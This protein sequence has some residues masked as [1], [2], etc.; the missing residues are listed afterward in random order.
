MSYQ[1]YCSHY[2]SSCSSSSSGRS[3][4]WCYTCNW[5]PLQS[6]R[7]ICAEEKMAVHK[8]GI[9]CTFNQQQTHEKGYYLF[10]FCIKSTINRLMM[11]YAKF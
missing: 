1:C 7:L 4:C 3:N 11:K 6:M 9:K 8:C 10:Q 5:W 2:I